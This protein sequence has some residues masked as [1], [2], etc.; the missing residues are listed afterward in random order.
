MSLNLAI[1][2]GAEMEEYMTKIGRELPQYQGNESWMLPIPATFRGRQG[3]PDQGALRRSGLSQAHG[4]RRSDRRAKIKLTKLFSRPIRR[5]Q[6]LHESRGDRRALPAGD[7]VEANVAPE[8]EFLQRACAPGF[9]ARSPCAAESR[10]RYWLRAAPAD[11]GPTI[12][13]GDGR[14]SSPL[15]RSISASSAHFSQ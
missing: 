8:L 3:R 2:V 12:P 5:A 7:A 6:H 10:C 9:A 14:H 15:A 4:G 11:P 1:W 13:R